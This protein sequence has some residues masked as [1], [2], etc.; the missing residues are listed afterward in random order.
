[1][2]YVL[3]LL[4]PPPPPPPP[5]LRALRADLPHSHPFTYPLTRTA[6][7][8]ESDVGGTPDLPDQNFNYTCTQ[9][10]MITQWRAAFQVPDAFF[11]VV[12]LSTW[13]YPHAGETGT[14]PHLLAAMRDQQLASAAALGKGFAYGTNA[15]YGAGNNIHPPYKQHVGQRLANAALSIVYAQPINWRSPTYAAATA[16]AVGAAAA[17]TSVTVSLNDVEG[18]LVLK[19]AFNRGTAPKNC[20]ALNNANPGTCAFGSIQFDDAARSWVNA[21]VGLSADMKAIV[22]GA[23]A[24]AGATKV[25]ATSYGWG[26]VPMMTVYR[27]DMDGEDGQLPVLPWNKTMLP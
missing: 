11:A 18:G 14:V 7:Q 16:T 4:P 26:S 22:L 2:V 24:P 25:I 23:A 13:L 17:S 6:D 5:T 12:Q 10:A 1:M 15:D 27:A 8:G 20:A 21:S 9:T 3:S 19:D